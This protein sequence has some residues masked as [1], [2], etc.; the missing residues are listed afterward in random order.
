[1]SF[2]KLTIWSIGHE[3]GDFFL[4]FFPSIFFIIYYNA[5]LYIF[6][7]Y[8]P[9]KLIWKSPQFPVAHDLRSSVLCGG[10]D[11]LRSFEI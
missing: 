9:L 4:A 6:H 8:T 3:K 1:M 7:F 11:A 5:P 10:D 2:R